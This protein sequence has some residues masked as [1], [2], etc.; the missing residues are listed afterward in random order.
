MSCGYIKK[1]KPVKI[2]TASKDSYVELYDRSITPNNVTWQMDKSLIT[3]LW[4]MVESWRP[5]K[6]FTGVNT[7]RNQATHKFT[8]DYRNDIENK[9]L[10]KYDGINYEIDDFENIDEENISMALYLHRLGNNGL[11]VNDSW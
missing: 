9:Q 5:Y 2:C 4:A 8:I 11:P 3:P 7:D 10:I 6:N 1:K